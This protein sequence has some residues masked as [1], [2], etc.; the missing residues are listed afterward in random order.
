VQTLKLIIP[1]SY[2]D[3]QIYS[4]RLYLWSNNGSIITFDWDKLI[5]SICIPKHLK[6]AITCAFLKSE[7]LYGDHWKL[8]FEDTEIKTTIEHKFQELASLTPIEFSTQELGKHCI[9]EQSNPFAFPHSDC[10]IYNNIMYLGSKNGVALA[11]CGRKTKNPISSKPKKIWDGTALCLT[12]SYNRLAIS[13]GNDGLFEYNLEVNHYTD[14]KLH[15]PKALINHHSNLVRWLYASLFSSSYFNEGYLADYTLQDSENEEGGFKKRVLREIIPS[16]TMFGHQI[17]NDSPT[18][19]WGLHDKICLATPKSVE[20]IQYNPY[21]E[22]KIFSRLGEVQIDNTISDIISGDNALF[23]IILESE[24]GLLV[25]NSILESMWLEGE[26]VNW[27]VYPKSKFYTNQLHVIHE[28]HLCIH[29]FN[30]DYFIDQ[31]SKIIGIRRPK[32]FSFPGRR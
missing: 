24:D 31:K 9:K 5:E 29:S 13:A 6:L 20:V 26:P 32:D 1:G 27:R 25:I 2:Y 10:T 3:S 30:H 14:S 21:N 18:F 8:F 28:D 15:E 4:G 22:E 16:S 12:A 19:T 7:Y 17:Q 23:G 11:T